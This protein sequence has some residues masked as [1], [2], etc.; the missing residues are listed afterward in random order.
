MSDRAAWQLPAFI[1]TVLAPR[2]HDQALV[3][4]VIN[5]GTRIAVQLERLAA[6]VPPVDIVIADGGS[7]DGALVPDAL[8]R[9]G[10]CALLVKTGPGGVAENTPLDRLL[11]GRLVHAPLLSLAARASR[12]GYRVTEILVAR[13]Y[14]RH[15]P[16]PRKIA[17]WHGRFAMLGELFGAALS[18]FDPR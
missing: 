1:T 16:T 2:R 10:A 12:L 6:A 18:R 17:G 9:L 8:R 15:V 3:I 4:P 7:P 11:A 13:H 5:A 14:P